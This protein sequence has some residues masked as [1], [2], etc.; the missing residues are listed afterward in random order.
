RRRVRWA[1]E[2][3]GW[4]MW[5][6]D[7]IVEIAKVQRHLLGG[8]INLRVCEVSKIELI[9]SLGCRGSDGIA[10]DAPRQTDPGHPPIIDWRAVRIASIDVDV[11]HRLRVLA[12]EET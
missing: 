10:L 3:R 6:A 9:E 5:L 2:D 8:F 7:K 4:K 11:Q 1:V 12:G